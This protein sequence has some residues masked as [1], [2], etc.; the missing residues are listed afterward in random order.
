MRKSIRLVLMSF[1]AGSLVVGAAFAGVLLSP[2]DKALSPQKKDV[3]TA[4]VLS[5]AS[6]GSGE[7]LGADELLVGVA[8]VNIYPNPP[9]GAHWERNKAACLPLSSGGA[10]P[11]GILDHAADPTLPWVENPNCIYMGGYGIGPTNPAI[12]FDD[13]S[14]PAVD[15]SGPYDG[16]YGLWVRSIAFQRDG[17]A[18]VLTLVDATYYFGEYNA[19]CEQPCGGFDLQAQMSAETGHLPESFIF[20]ST[21]SHTAPDL[22]GGWGGVPKWY[23]TQVTNAMKEAARQA[24]ATAVPGVIIAEET[25]ARPFNRE[26]RD[27]YYSAEDHT[28]SW[29]RALDRNGSTVGTVAAYGAH[30]TSFSVG[31]GTAHPDWHGPVSKRFEERFGGVGIIFP[32]GLG[33]MSARLG[34]TTNYAPARALADLLPESGT[35][36]TNPVIRAKQVFWNQPVTNSGLAALG[37]ARFFDRKIGDG[38][39]TISAGKSSNKPC[40]S[41]SPISAKTAITAAKIGNVWIAGTPGEIF[42]NISN[43]IKERAAPSPALVFGMSND[44]L[45][46]IMQSFETDHAA[47]QVLGFVGADFFEYEDAYS[48]D[49]C[50]GDMVLTTILSTMGS[51]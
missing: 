8:K 25:P 36:V 1:L 42:S 24:L 26:R 48:I 3:S 20:A 28:V 11:Q 33:N 6:L 27:T 40:M 43:T 17:K 21:H 15:G 23:M 16:G 10:N 39:A 30:P 47:R 18:L 37:G 13:P 14:R 9:E 51:L 46:Y 19:M 4:G 50:F 29:I 12:E 35:L 45:G 2:L 41:G 7:N 32:S 38:P 49:A 34:G 31:R 22:I 44:G 5:L